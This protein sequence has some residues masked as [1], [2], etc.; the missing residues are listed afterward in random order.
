M[1]LDKCSDVLG[2]AGACLRTV[3]KPAAQY[4]LFPGK[5]S[6]IILFLSICAFFA[7]FL[8]VCFI[9]QR[10]DN[11]KSQKEFDFFKTAACTVTAFLFFLEFI[12]LYLLN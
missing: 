9:T 8:L 5:I 2:L 7:I 6:L 4:I 10:N 12:I 11:K 1:H 3:K